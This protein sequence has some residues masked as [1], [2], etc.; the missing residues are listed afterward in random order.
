MRVFARMVCLGGLLLAVQAHAANVIGGR[1]V[2]RNGQPLP[3]AIISLSPG[4][5]ELVT[6]Q[7]GRFVINYLRDPSGERIK[8]DSKT[9]YKLE[10]F[11]TGYH[12]FTTE[13]S[14]RRGLL[15]VETVTMVEET[16]DVQDLADIIDPA[17][18]SSSTQSSGASYIGN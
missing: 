9:D 3:R 1:V 6:D 15:E 2:N 12:T 11:L 5:V 10:V 7:D 14:Y 17:R 13:V 4:N 16:L 8:L 18:Y